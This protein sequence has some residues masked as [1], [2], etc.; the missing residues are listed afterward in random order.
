MRR[1]RSLNTLA[2]L[3]LAFLDS[4]AGAQPKPP[5]LDRYGDPLPE[6]AIM[7]I[8]TV[9]LR[10]GGRIDSMA[11]TADSKKLVTANR[12]SGVQ[13]WDVASG[14][15]LRAL[16]SI[17]KD[18]PR[19]HEPSPYAT[20][21]LS[22]KGTHVAEVNNRSVCSVRA[23]AT[24][25]E[26]FRIDRKH[27]QNLCHVRF[28]PDG[29]T[30]ALLANVNGEVTIFDV[31]TGKLLR[32]LPEKHQACYPF[33]AFSPDGNTL[34]VAAQ[35]IP[36]IHYNIASGQRVGEF[37]DA[38][39][40]SFSSGAFS[41]DGKFF[42]YLSKYCTR[43][44]VWD[45]ATRKQLAALPG[46]ASN[47]SPIIFSPDSRWVIS[48]FGESQLGIW[49]AATGKLVRT[50][51]DRYGGFWQTAVSP[52]GKLL[53]TAH[54][55][56]V[57]LW[58]LDTGKPLHHF[59]GH[60]GHSVNV[61]FGRDNKTV[62]TTSPGRVHGTD[63]SA[64]I[65]D[66]ATGKQLADVSWAGGVWPVGAVSADGRVQAQGRGGE[67]I[68]V[69]DLATA[70]VLLEVDEPGYVPN[71]MAL[72]PD[73]KRLMVTLHQPISNG[74]YKLE[75]WDVGTGKKLLERTGYGHAELDAA[76]RRLLV[77]SNDG[78]AKH[79]QCYDAA[80]GRL[81]PR[82][83]ARVGN[84]RIV[85][86]PNGRLTAEAAWD[87]TPVKLR[88]LATGEIVGEL[89]PPRGQTIIELAFSPNGLLLAA[90][91]AEGPIF[92][93]DVVNQRELAHLPGHRS[94]ARSLSWSPDGTRLASGSDD[95]TVL[96]WNAEPWRIRAAP[97]EVKLTPQQL[98][99]L[100]D[101]L[102]EVKGDRGYRAVIRLGQAPEGSVAMLR[103]HLRPT[104][105][106]EVARV[107]TLIENLGDA[108]FSV[109]TRANL[110][111]EKL[112]D[113]AIPALEKAL[114]SQPTLETRLRIEKLLRKLGAEPPFAAEPP[115]AAQ[116]QQLRALTVLEMIGTREAD[117][118]LDLLARGAPESWLT[119]EALAA[120]QRLAESRRP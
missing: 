54:G 60:A 67:K 31:A 58:R 17:N 49:E 107:R 98:A 61:Q 111:L 19:W 32:T 106:Q 114:A 104:T 15:E 76:G 83:H 44:E 47:C 80:T 37:G 38:K 10:A 9:R 95:M 119:R 28:S 16:S 88:E 43:L 63:T 112:G 90:G 82:A 93:W 99:Q 25:K 36:V 42:A 26:L 113:L 34:A 11:F 109:R 89:D 69:R 84:H 40:G 59:P 81:T 53:A 7:R 1:Y 13:V 56:I 73:G 79:L 33:L 27:W 23:V 87:G 3:A 72:T 14:E 103:K 66:A 118:V 18:E 74:G 110:E 30:L 5:R 41:P 78:Q 20:I 6:G 48:R 91:T 24:G 70:K 96:V 22:P 55:Q 51:S 71:N 52:D 50:F 120:K 62:I 39:D 12:A 77:Y 46:P 101:D 45:V 65:W 105:A 85:L 115:P 8:G 21:L 94:W 102:A 35:N 86:S 68:V 108:R 75:L 116:L 29:K 64:F 100:W 97:I 2:L 117:A 57:E 4:S 92:I